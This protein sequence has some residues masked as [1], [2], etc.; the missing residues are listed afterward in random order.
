VG[1]VELIAPWL[2]I[3]FTL[4]AALLQTV[5]NAVQRGLTG[6]LGA[7]GA[8]YIRF[9]YG[10]PFGLLFLVIILAA[11]GT[12]PVVPG[13]LAFG[14]TFSGALAQIGATLML[15]LAMRDRSF[16]VVTAYS[17]TEP[18]QVAIFGLVLLG[19]HLTWPL[20]LA[21]VTATAGVLLMS[22]PKAGEGRFTLSASLYGIGS[23]ALFGIASVC[24]R[25]AILT[26]PD[27]GYL[28]AAGTTL[29]LNLLI[30]TVMFTAWLLWRDP[31][32]FRAA[33]REWRASLPA[34]FAGAM[35]SEGWFLAFA[36]E[37]AARVRTLALVEILFAQFIAWRV[38][39]QGA[40]I[41]DWL[42]IALI[43]AGVI[44]LLNS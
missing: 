25:G 10:L 11:T 31:A 23:A 35:A 12:A 22:W 14:W 38:F 6:P 32:T 24:F 13:L 36:L 1:I 19:D 28:V 20:S 39:R 9:L 7:S 5:R 21:I 30:Q 43:A 40:G 2:W 34:G 16:V 15:L 33:L 4:G 27:A 42:G 17:K 18:V 26:M 8:T 37:S 41:R 3:A 44:W 29:A